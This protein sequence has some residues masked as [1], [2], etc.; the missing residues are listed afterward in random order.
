[1]EQ[2]KVGVLLSGCGV[3]D[4]AEIHE[5]VLTL[6]YL[7]Q[8]GAKAVCMA[9]DID[10]AHVVN[11]LTNAE[12]A[13][14]R[15]V[16]VESARICRGEIRNLAEV[17]ADDIDALIV[18][19][20]FGAAKNLSEFASKGPAGA[21]NSQV[22]RILEELIEAGKPI[23]ALCIAPATVGMAL[24]EKGPLM[25]VGKDENVIGALTTIG[26]KHRLCAVDDITVDEAHKIVT[27]PAYMIG[28]GIRDVSMGIEKLVKKVLALA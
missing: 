28:P 3:F 26:V 10:Q 12:M 23:G 6:L 21:V 20:G 19:G 16:L 9:P 2:K 24:K 13:E 22:Q 15:N 27:T 11:H 7:D 18:P 17:T 5:A 8:Q 25:T 4:G 1:M 14:T